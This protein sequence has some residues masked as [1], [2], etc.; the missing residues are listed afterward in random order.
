LDAEDLAIVGLADTNGLETKFLVML[1]DSEKTPIE[2]IAG[3]TSD[4]IGD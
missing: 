2:E 4:Q 1:L 3:A